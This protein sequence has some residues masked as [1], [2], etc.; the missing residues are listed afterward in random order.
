M[1]YV[2]GHRADF[3]EWASLGNRGWS[4]D[5][6]LP[7]FKRSEDNSRGL[8][9]YR[10]A[11]GPLAVSDLRDPNPLSLAFV[12]A[13]IEAGTPRND[14]YNGATQ[15]G[16]SLVQVNQRKGKRCSAADAFLRPVLRRPN[17]KVT[18]RAHATRIIFNGR[19]ATGVAYL[20]DGREEIAYADHEVILCGGAFNSPQLLMLS[21]VGPADAIREHGLKVIQDLPGVGSNLQDHPAGKLMVRCTRPLTLL[22]AESMGNLL[23]YLLLGR[24]M[25]TSNGPEAVAFVRTRPELEAPDVE[26]ILMPMLFINEGLAPPP[27]HGFT[28]GAMLFK[29]KSRGQLTLRSA[30]P[31]DA[32]VISTN[33]LSD[34]EGSDL[35]TIVEGLK[36]ARR[37]VASPSLAQY[38][39][40]EL[41]PG[42]GANS[43]AELAAAVRAEGQTIYHPVGTCKMGLDAMAVVD[44]TLRVHG[45]EG[46]RVIDASVMPTIT[47]GHTHAP[48]VMIAEKGSDLIAAD[49]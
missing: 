20:R 31:L 48:T 6:V 8:S 36:I 43:D 14:D 1:M 27:E 12:Q 41:V 23:R 28:I 35:A 5:E 10:G 47:R 11:G 9:A 44:A 22:A 2:R 46:L 29:P 26:L 15:D 37:I 33:H 7:Y 19:R 24:G 42:A 34:A 21:G 13:A 3:D 25:L 39:D 40:G 30:N 4:Y 17:L 18:T 32:P 38:C 49:C 16:A 45:L